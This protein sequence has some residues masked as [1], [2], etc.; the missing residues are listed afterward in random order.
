MLGAHVAMNPFPFPA[1]F[2]PRLKFFSAY[3]PMWACRDDPRVYT[4][5]DHRG[6]RNTHSEDFLFGFS[7]ITGLAQLLAFG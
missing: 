3:L 2:R 6:D 5:E 4:R 7:T 1:R